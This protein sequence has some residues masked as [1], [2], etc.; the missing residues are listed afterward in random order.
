MEEL[1]RRV[2]VCGK[3]PQKRIKAMEDLQDLILDSIV[4][5]DSFKVKIIKKA[6]DIMRE[7]YDLGEVQVIRTEIDSFDKKK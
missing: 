6:E 4:I 2:Y 1:R 7:S 5:S 3:N